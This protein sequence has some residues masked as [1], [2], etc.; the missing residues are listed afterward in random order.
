M[1]RVNTKQRSAARKLDRRKRRLARRCGREGRDCPPTP[2]LDTRATRYDVSE[3]DLGTNAAGV[4]AIH[5]VATYLHL[6]EEINRHVPLLKVHLPYHESDHVL[7]M[8][9]NLMAG[10]TRLQDLELRR[11]DEAFMN[12]LG[13][14]RLPDPTT[15]GDFLRR[16]TAP[17]IVD[18]LMDGIN[19]ARVRAWEVSPHLRDAEAIIDVDGSIAPTDGEKKEGVDIAYNGIWGYHPLFV[20]LAN[21]NEEL[22]ILNRSG[23]RPSHEGS[24]PYIDKSIELCRPYFRSIMVRGDSDFALTKNFDRWSNAGVKFVFSFDTTK[25][26]I[27]HAQAL[28]N[29]AWARL[30]RNRRQPA[31][32][33]RTTRD[34]EK[35]ARVIA[36]GFENITL[37][38][39]SVAEFTYR[40]DACARDYRVV[41]LRK[42]LV[43]KKGQAVLYPDIRYFFYITNDMTAPKE[44]IVFL[45]NGRCNQENVIEQ[46]KNGVNAMRVPVYDLVS[47][48]A[49]M[50]IA[51]LAWNLKAWFALLQV[52]AQ[53]ATTLLAM[54]FR[55]F[56]NYVILVPAQVIRKA[57]QVVVRII[58][59]TPGVRMLFS[60]L[61]RIGRH[62]RL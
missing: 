32:E 39:E 53:D 49:Y 19:A 13:A 22:F 6:D 35:E 31:G 26:L 10:G 55:T 54:E 12:M 59:Y 23:N 34:N 50:V 28:P 58:G 3:R 60:P 21:T 9:Y 48:W 4:A 51:A 56:I 25:N 38:S 17:V 62:A 52:R 5:K 41:A 18:M 40:P 20:T 14:S 2:V 29:G 42:V 16:F 44:E 45:S 36:R 27:E 61:R 1:I 33:P 8:A 11:T 43:V 30:E 47:N 46:M 57:H 37:E 24:V 7:T 15:E